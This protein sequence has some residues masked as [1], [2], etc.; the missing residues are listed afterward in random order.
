MHPACTQLSYSQIKALLELKT[1]RHRWERARH[2]VCLLFYYCRFSGAD[3]IVALM[4]APVNQP[5]FLLLAM[6]AIHSPLQA[7]SEWV[8]KYNWITNK[9]R[10]TLVRPSAN[11]MM[12]C[13]TLSIFHECVC[14]DR[15]NRRA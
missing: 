7:P 9:D 14:H 5:F 4:Q 1:T 10:R 2:L 12:S 8:D 11:V 15:Y 6:Q 3:G 13:F